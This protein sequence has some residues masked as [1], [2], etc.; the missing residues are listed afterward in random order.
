MKTK[1][2]FITLG[3]ALTVGAGVVAGVTLSRGEAVKAEA[4]A[5]ITSVTLKGSFDSWGSGIAFTKDSNDDWNLT[6]SLLVGDEFKIAV[7]GGNEEWVGYSW[8][9]DASNIDYDYIGDAG[10]TDHN[11]KVTSAQ[12]FVFKVKS[13]FYTNYGSDVIIKKNTAVTYTVSYDEDGDGTAEQTEVVTANGTIVGYTPVKFGYTF[14]YWTL[15]GSQ[16]NTSSPVTTNITLTAHWTELAGKKYI[17]IATGYNGSWTNRYIFGYGDSNGYGAW[18][19]TKVSDLVEETTVAANFGGGNDG[20]LNGGLMKVPYYTEYGMTHIILNNGNGGDANQ[21]ENLPLV[22]N[23]CYFFLVKTDERASDYAAQA[24]ITS[25]GKAATVVFAF[26]DEFGT[27]DP[28]CSTAPAK[29]GELYN[30]YYDASLRDDVAKGWMD[31]SVVTTD[32]IGVGVAAAAMKMIVDKANLNGAN[33]VLHG[34]INQPFSILSS[35]SNSIAIFAL[36][37]LSTG[38]VAVGGF[39]FIRKRKENN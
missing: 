24:R 6:H 10:G 39:F 34:L 13:T 33:I 38:L 37:A 20:L 4:A 1:N 36:I 3:L 22:E 9:I 18:P 30:T 11:F 32:N 23:G 28:H 19:G 7:T 25:V 31:N 12:S 16:Y 15:A 14:D 29:A 35:D 26:D 27:T 5:T 17:Y 2:L 21:T 8:G